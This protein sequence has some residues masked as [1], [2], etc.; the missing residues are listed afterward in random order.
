MHKEAQQATGGPTFLWATSEEG[1]Y[2]QL[3]SDKTKSA[4][5]GLKT[6]HTDLGTNKESRSDEISK[7]IMLEDLSNLM[8]DTRSAFL[9]PDSPND[10]PIIVSD[11]NEK[12]EIKRYKDTYTT[13]YDGPEDTLIPHPL[14]P[15]S[16]QIQELMAQVHLLQSRKDKLEQQ[17]AKAEAEELPAEFLGLPSQISSFQEKL[18]TL[19]VLLSLLHKVTETLN[20]FATIMENASKKATDKGVPSAGYAS[21][22][23]TEGEKN[24]NQATKDADNANLN[25]QPTTTTPPTTS[26]FQSPLFPKRKGK[27]VMSSK[28]AE[29][30]ET[31]SDFEDDHANPA[32]T[33]TKSSKQKKLKKFNFFIEGGEQIHITAMKIEEQE[34]LRISQS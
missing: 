7:K 26:S 8:Q 18:K 20:R 25:Q 6:A 22:S 23:L 15:K 4:R 14:S 3:N 10:E 9:T 27:K 24:T 11:E 12:E 13:S 30:D 32:K 16:V 33:I 5:N 1:A 34:D 2:P 31:E 19:D 17:K 21:A 29:D 28:D